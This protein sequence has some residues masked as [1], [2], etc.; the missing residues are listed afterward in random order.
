VLPISLSRSSGITKVGG[1]SKS[2]IILTYISSIMHVTAIL[3]A[4]FLSAAT[5]VSADWAI[6]TTTYHFSTTFTK[7]ADVSPLLSLRPSSLFTSY[8]PIFPSSTNKFCLGHKMGSQEGLRDLQSLVN[9]PH[10]RHRRPSICFRHQSRT[11]RASNCYR[12]TRRGPGYRH[13]YN[14]HYCP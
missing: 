14:V 11:R 7:E 1:A 12:R 13:H 2:N 6:V 5:L 3:V 8:F 4:G 9:L 10:P